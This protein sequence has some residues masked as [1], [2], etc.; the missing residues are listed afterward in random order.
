MAFCHYRPNGRLSSVDREPE[1]EGRS[2]ALHEFEFSNTL[3]GR[4]RSFIHQLAGRW[5]IRSLIQQQNEINIQ[6]NLT[7]DYLKKNFQELDQE[8]VQTRKQLAELTTLVVQQ[9][10]KIEQLEANQQEKE[11]G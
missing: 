9:Q 11:N 4:L 3:V 6:Q 7:G 10:K 5:A 8:L 2:V 1:Q